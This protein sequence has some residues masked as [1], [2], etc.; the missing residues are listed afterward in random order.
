MHTL[1]RRRSRGKARNKMLLGVSV[2]LTLV[3][4]GAC[5]AVGYVVS[6]AAEAP[7]LDSIKPRDPGRLSSVYTEDGTRLGFIQADDLRQVVSSDRFPKVLRD[8][9]VAI[10]DERFYKHKGVDYEGVIRAAVKNLRSG[11]TVEG[12]STIT[13]QL[14]RNLYI[15]KERTYK[16]K[17]QEA[18]LAEELENERSKTWILNHYLNS[19]PY[20][21]EGGQTAVGAQAASRLYFGK[22][23]DKLKLHEAAML[24]G[25]P[26]APSQYSPFKYHDKAL[27]RRNEVIYRMAQQRLITRAEADEASQRDLGVKLSRF[28]RARRESYFFDY[29]KNELL[30]EYG[31]KTVKSG[32]LRITTTIDLKKQKAARAAIA[33]VLNQP[34]DPSSAIVTIDQKT[35]YIRAMASSADYGKSKFNLAAQGHR[36]PGSTFKIMT[37]MTAL[38]RGVDPDRTSYVSKPLSF[39]ADSPWGAFTTKTYDGS[40]GGSMSLTRGT[41]KSDNTVYMQLALDLG[42]EEVKRTAQDMG[43][44]SKLNGYPAESLGGLEDGVSPLEMANAYATIASGGYRNRPIAIKSVRFPDGHTEKPF[45]IKRVK[46]FEDGVTAKA[47]DILVKN[48]QGGTGGKASDRLPGGR[49]DRH[50][51]PLHRRLVR[52][53]HA[54]P[55]DG[56]V[57]RLPGQQPD[58]DAQRARHLRRRRH[59]PG[60]D[61]G[62]LH[63]RGEGLLLRRVPQAHD[64]VRLVALLRQVLQ[65]GQRRRRGGRS[66]RR[67]D[68]RRSEGHPRRQARRGPARRRQRRRRR[69]QARSRRR[70]AVRS[71]ALR[72]AAAGVAGQRRRRQQRQ[73]QGNGG[74]GKEPV[75]VTPGTPEEAPEVDPNGGAQPPVLDPG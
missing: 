56:G 37:L 35:G 40:Y 61:L 33:G 18:K 75:P 20:G 13:M 51:R 62:P 34:G 60:R 12:G 16:R 1:R 72:G 64:A 71:R 68:P 19:I 66:R 23:V 44:R 32:G 73:R 47:T 42:P 4:I 58:R 69:R 21:T 10:E 41:L 24:A 6:I 14:V 63:E 11:K 30:H 53:L 59:L 55:D 39:G 54:A 22:S 28:Y 31:A 70:R 52:R 50:H 27:A 5:S 74:K 8:A 49:Q 7:D 29:V 65:D 25:L 36:Q 67:R 43:I 38:R 45:K 17:I 26:Q 3:I 9:T 15:G 48:I 46:E 57:G 2:L